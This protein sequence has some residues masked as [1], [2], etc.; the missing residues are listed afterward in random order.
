MIVFLA[1][2]IA[3]ALI[4]LTIYAFWDIVIV[5]FKIWLFNLIISVIG[6]LW[7]FV[8]FHDTFMKLMQR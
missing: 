8:V 4:A 2:I 5:L 6:G 7:F 1:T 3:L